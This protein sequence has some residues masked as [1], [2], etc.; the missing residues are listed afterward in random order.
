MAGILARKV[1]VGGTAETAAEKMPCGAVEK[2][3]STTSPHEPKM[4]SCKKAQ[5]GN[6]C[7]VF[8]KVEEI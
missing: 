3:G 5:G 1:G 4:T 7:W 6:E 8:L 2:A